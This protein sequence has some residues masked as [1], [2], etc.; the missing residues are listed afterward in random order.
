[1]MLAAGEDRFWEEE[2]GRAAAA[3]VA[4]A[5]LRVRCPGRPAW[6][7][8]SRDSPATP[9]LPLASARRQV[10][11]GG[12]RRSAARQ[13]PG[14]EAGRRRGSRGRRRP[15]Q[16]MPAHAPALAGAALRPGKVAGPVRG[17]VGCSRALALGAGPRGGGAPGSRRRASALRE[18]RAAGG[19]RGLRAPGLG[20]RLPSSEM[21]VCPSVPGPTASAAGYR[22][23]RAACSSGCPRLEI[24]RTIASTW[25]PN[26]LKSTSS[27][28]PL[29]CIPEVAPRSP[30]REPLRPPPPGGSPA[31]LGGRLA[32]RT[33]RR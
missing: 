3:T 24:T 7:C 16:E 26:S 17:L 8:S 33:E 14:G 32:G 10:R 25:S 30:A 23:R 2:G 11:R 27:H 12:A 21:S 4:P 9:A 1:M 5:F 15:H 13:Q 29:I 19:R 18:D 28:Q 20:R 6:G 22:G 31:G